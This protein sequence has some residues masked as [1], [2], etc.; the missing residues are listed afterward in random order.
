MVV[1]YGPPDNA[2]EYGVKIIDAQI[3]PVGKD[4]AK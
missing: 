4:E 3:P 1:F 2:A